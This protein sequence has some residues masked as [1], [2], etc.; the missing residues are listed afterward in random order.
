MI[1]DIDIKT[2]DL[3][4]IWVV[5]KDKM[6]H[7]GKNISCDL[8]VAYVSFLSGDEGRLYYSKSKMTKTDYILGKCWE[9]DVS[10][11]EARNRFEEL[12]NKKGTKVFHY[13]KADD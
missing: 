7:N 5:A 3:E 12:L 13:C 11:N 6:K 9:E 8:K 1:N 4:K 10:E 2:Q